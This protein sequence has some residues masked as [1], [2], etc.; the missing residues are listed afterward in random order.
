MI[1]REVVTVILVLGLLVSAVPLMFKKEPVQTC[2]VNI[3][4]KENPVQTW[5][6]CDEVPEKWIEHKV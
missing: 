6:P 3:G 1:V 4:T 5:I 2:F